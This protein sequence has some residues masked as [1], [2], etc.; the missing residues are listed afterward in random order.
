M[1]KNPEE[2]L[3]SGNCHCTAVQFTVLAPRDLILWRCNCSIC[4][5]KQNH[6]F[7]V[8][9]QKFTL[10]QGKDKL[11]LYTF[12]TK[13]AKHYFCKICGVQS[14]YHP[15]SNP[16]GVAIT[17]NCIKNKEDCS[18]VKINDFDG[19]NWEQTMKKVDIAKFSK[20]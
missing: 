6:H 5:M 1:Q 7:I 17:F 16:D 19:E 10:T 20:L 3:L 8:P 18:S 9:K 12:N 14:F 15:R 11:T 4:Q 2:I 13:V